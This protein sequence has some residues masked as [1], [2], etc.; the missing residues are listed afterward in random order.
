MVMQHFSIDS[1]GEL[2]LAFLF[3]LLS[4][5]DLLKPDSAIPGKNE[6]PEHKSYF[7]LTET[8]SKG[9]LFYVELSSSYEAY[10]SFFYYFFSVDQRR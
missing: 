7:R 3:L 5:Q 2:F 1:G 6:C 4:G 8:K 10:I 9:G